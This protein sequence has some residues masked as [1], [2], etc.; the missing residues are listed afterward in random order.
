MSKNVILVPDLNERYDIFK[1][2][3]ENL[4]DF[5]EK[6]DKKS[7]IEELTLNSI[8]NLYKEKEEE[9]SLILNYMDIFFLYVYVMSNVNL[10]EQADL[11][12]SIFSSEMF[13][14]RRFNRQ[15]SLFYILFFLE[16]LL[17]ERLENDISKGNDLVN[18]KI[19]LI[20]V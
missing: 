6:I 19:E 16:T 15:N 14:K 12:E 11:P 3:I 5:L 13:F 18:D 20:S 17:K 4:N 8:K 1:I 9:D 10:Q 7:K 2:C